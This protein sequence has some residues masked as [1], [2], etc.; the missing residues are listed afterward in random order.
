[1]V[2]LL[3]RIVLST[4][5]SAGLRNGDPFVKANVRRLQ[6]IGTFL[7]LM[8]LVSVGC[9][10]AAAELVLDSAVKDSAILPF[11]VNFVWLWMGGLVLILSEVFAAGVRLREDVEGLV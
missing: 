7:M 11:D 1:M 2:W 3:R 4:I 5:G 9:Q 8:P 6:L 10:I